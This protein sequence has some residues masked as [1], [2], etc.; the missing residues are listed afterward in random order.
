MSPTQDHSLLSWSHLRRSTRTNMSGSTSQCDC[1]HYRRSRGST[2]NSCQA[3]DDLAFPMNPHEGNAALMRPSRAFYRSMPQIWRVV[4]GLWGSF[5]HG[6]RLSRKVY[7]V[8]DRE[9][10][11]AVETFNVHRIGIPYAAYWSY[12]PT[13]SLRARILSMHDIPFATNS[14]PLAVT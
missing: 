1:H 14:S 7:N 5:M 6:E 12:K 4:R 11:R 3:W 2:A 13:D 8:M 10:G 9:H